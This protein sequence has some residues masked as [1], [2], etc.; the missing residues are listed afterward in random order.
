MLQTQEAKQQKVKQIKFTQFNDSEKLQ[1]K[2]SVNTTLTNKT[3]KKDGNSTSAG[4]QTHTF[5]ENL[6]KCFPGQNHVL[7]VL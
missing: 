5:L 7:H 1:K 3:K 2:K 4:K 6:E